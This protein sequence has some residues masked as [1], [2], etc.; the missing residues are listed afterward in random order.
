MGNARDMQEAAHARMHMRTS[1]SAISWH[2]DTV[3]N[4]RA[5]SVLQC[6]MRRGMN[7]CHIPS[8]DFIGSCCN[9]LPRLFPMHMHCSLYRSRPLS[10][11]TRCL[12]VLISQLHYSR[13]STDSHRAARMNL[14]PCIVS[15]STSDGVSTNVTS[16]KFLVVGGE[17]LCLGGVR[18]YTGT[19]SS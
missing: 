9:K 6:T 1:A 12:F 2:C 11:A 17:R 13:L 7:V 19:F 4:P 15:V 18:Y 10:R 3:C 14:N 8:A 16:A 5:I